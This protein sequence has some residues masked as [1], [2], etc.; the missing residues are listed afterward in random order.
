MEE[1]T[2]VNAAEWDKRAREGNVW[3]LP[4]SHDEFARAQQGEWQ[5]LLTAIKPVPKS[6]FPPLAGCNLL[7]LASGGG[8]Q[9]P[10]FAALG[11]KVTVFDLSV[12][13]LDTELI[14]SDREGYTIQIVRGD[15]TE[16]FP[17]AD[18]SFDLVFHPVSNC[19]IRDVEPVWRE[20]YRVLK[21]GGRLLAGFTNPCV[22]L[23]DEAGERKVVRKLPY[24]PIVGAA[25]TDLEA[26]AAKGAI[27]FS[28][29]L[30]KQIGGQ[31]RAG[32]LLRDMYEDTDREAPLAEFFPHYMATY[33][34]KPV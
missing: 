13:Q 31:L 7:G 9:C 20:V 8:Q 12:K 1:Y 24:D 11:A 33:A 25:S 34:V 22:Y 29:T 32:F 14:M 4:I 27:E 19:Y 2:R 18:A 28:H 16:P 5:V 15:M 10:I 26:L 23:F 30:D 3:T 21:P 17:F 6:W